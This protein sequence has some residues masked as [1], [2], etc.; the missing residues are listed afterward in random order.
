MADVPVGCPWCPGVW[1]A[2]F[3]GVTNGTTYTADCDCPPVESFLDGLDPR[4]TEQRE[5]T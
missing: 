3:N 2:T 1:L 4:P 5:N